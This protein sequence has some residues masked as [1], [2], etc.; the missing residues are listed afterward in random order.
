VGA[1]LGYQGQVIAREVH[2]T[3]LPGDPAEHA[4]QEGA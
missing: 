2:L 3:P 4:T 1:P